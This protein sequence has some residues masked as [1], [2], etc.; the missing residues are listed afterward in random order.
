MLPPTSK[1][2]DRAMHEVDTLIIG[3]G[4]LGLA[5]AARLGKPDTLI[6]EAEG[7]IGSHTSS[8]NSEVI[9]AGLYYP[10]GSLKAELCLEGR[11]RL[12]A[13]C[14]KHG[15]AHRRIGKLLVAVQESEICKLEALAANAEACGVTDLQQI[16][17]PRLH[18]LEP[19]MRGVRA[20]LSPS[21]G[22]IDS[23]A[24]LQSLL[25]VA[26]SRG[27]QLVLHSRVERLQRDGDAWVASGHSAG[28]AF[29]LRAKRVINAGGPFAQHLADT[30]EGL[31]V[32]P[33]HLCQG[34]YFSYSG[35]SPFSRLIY[36]MPEANTA[37]LGIHATLDLA[38]Q[39]RF[40]PDVRWLETLDY[41]VDENLRAPFAAAIARYFP[42]LD[43]TR[44]QPG[45]AG[46][47]AKLSGPGEP[48]ADFL[49]Q[50]PADHRL[51]GLVNLFGIESPGLTASLAIAE[52]V[53]GAL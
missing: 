43:A 9:H 29:T 15:V 36:P 4:A 19:A 8:R 34:R 22:I 20:L 1:H 40:G 48:A 30:I 23:H 42:A 21:T 28:E 37:G 2:T 24:Y 53:A 3:A 49:I 25:V 51:P 46:V 7:L 32:P 31:P 44:L 16:D 14:N 18:E 26:E 5:C 45:Y 13:W 38:G 27:A 41:A 50:T 6:L 12:Y 35:R 10:P 39:L 52:R 47:R 17:R 33:L 11:E